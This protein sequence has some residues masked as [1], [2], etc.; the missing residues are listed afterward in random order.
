[1]LPLVPASEFFMKTLKITV[2]S[3]FGCFALLLCGASTA[4]ASPINQ[5]FL[6]QNSGWMLPLY[7]DPNSRFKELITNVAGRVHG[8]G[9]GETVVASFNQSVG[10]QK[11]PALIYKGADKAQ[12]NAAIG[13]IQPARVDAR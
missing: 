5:V 12:L 8:H 6:V 2:A 1:M 13:S 11:S 3:L 9:A 10:E 7:D 4:S